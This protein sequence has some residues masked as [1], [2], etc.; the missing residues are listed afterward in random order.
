MRINVYSQELTKKSSRFKTADTGI[1]TGVFRLLSRVPGMSFTIPRRMMNRSA[2]TFWIPN[3]RSFSK[4]GWR[5]CSESWLRWSMSCLT[6]GQRMSGRVRSASR[7]SNHSVASRSGPRRSASRAASAS[8]RCSSFHD[9][10]IPPC[11]R[12]LPDD[13]NP[14]EDSCRWSAWRF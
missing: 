14:G 3:A 11:V 12:D 4:S 1:A 5:P 8:P 9:G 6:T 7:G 2:I 10:P 13:T